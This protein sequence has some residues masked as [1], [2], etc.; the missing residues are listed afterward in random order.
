MGA[1]ST[2]RAS[3]ARAHPKFVV[4]VASS[5]DASTYTS[6]PDQEEEHGRKKLECYP[7]G[8]G[9]L[10]RFFSCLVTFGVG[11]MLVHLYTMTSNTRL[12]GLVDWGPRSFMSACL[13]A[14]TDRLDGGDAGC[15][16]GASKARV[17][18]YMDAKTTST[19]TRPAPPPM[20]IPRKDKGRLRRAE[21]VY[22]RILSTVEMFPSIS[23]LFVLALRADPSSCKRGHVLLLSHSRWRRCYESVWVGRV[24]HKLVAHREPILKNDL[25]LIKDAR[26]L[27]SKF[28]FARS[29]TTPPSHACEGV[30]T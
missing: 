17:Y 11:Y 27:S 21:S 10:K 20:G 26:T 8:A 30:E 3:E 12:R 2:V 6:G 9:S 19:R 29:N 1:A 15:V 7:C 13:L 4:P 5:L 24:I 16:G 23:L 25:S 18:G 28:R 22:Y 14:G